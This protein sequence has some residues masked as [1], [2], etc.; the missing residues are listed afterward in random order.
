MLLNLDHKL[1]NARKKKQT[2]F[3]L[4][5]IKLQIIVVVI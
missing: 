4:H 1:I 5:V 3:W 2:T